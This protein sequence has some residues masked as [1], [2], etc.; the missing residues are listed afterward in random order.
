MFRSDSTER[1]APAGRRRLAFTFVGLWL[2]AAAAGMGIVWDH[3][4]S[5]GVG[6]AAPDRWPAESRIP[7]EPGLPT[8]ILFAHPRCPCTRAS[9]GE[10]ALLM[11]RADGRLAARVLC[12]AAG[13]GPAD[14]GPSEIVAA[15]GSTPG[16]RVLADLDG[17]EARRFGA[18][19]SGQ[20]LLYDRGGRLVFR[21]GITAARGHAGGNAGLE[22]VLSFLRTG[23]P[24]PDRTPVFGCPLFGPAESTAAPPRPCPR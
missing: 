14:R 6:A 20:T 17:A 9:L 21:G 10:L 4:L 15:A 2:L 1:R 24:D 19:T 11:A 12:L 7:R 18:A 5:P 3:A 16:V 22:A 13:D 23:N 8:L